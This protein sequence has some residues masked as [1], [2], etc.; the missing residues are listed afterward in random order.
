MAWS[1]HID[2]WTQRGGSVQQLWTSGSGAI[3]VDGQGRILRLDRA[4]HDV[5]VFNAQLSLLGRFG[6]TRLSGP[7]GIA[8]DTAGNVYVS[9]GPMHRIVEFAP[10]MPTIGSFTP[11]SGIT[12]GQVTIA[13]TNLS[14]ATGVKFGRL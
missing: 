10:V 9:D 11:S 3:A 1:N 6:A 14:G 5:Q 12:G 13:G 4:A 2:V 7:N 8:V